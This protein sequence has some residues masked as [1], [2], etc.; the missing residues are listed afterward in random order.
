VDV[1]LAAMLV[2]SCLGFGLSSNTFVGPP[3]LLTYAPVTGCQLLCT[4]YHAVQ[5]ARISTKTSR[6]HAASRCCKQ[7]RLELPGS[8]CHPQVLS[9]TRGLAPYLVYWQE[10]ALLAA[11][12]GSG[13]PAALQLAQQLMQE[14][15]AVFVYR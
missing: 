9:R 15:Q 14:R 2:K 3:Q 10:L 7:A 13:T 5:A 11:Q 12:R 8:C 4:V 1:H 6:L